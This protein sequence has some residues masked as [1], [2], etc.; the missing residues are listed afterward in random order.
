MRYKDCAE[1]DLDDASSVNEERR[2]YLF[3]T[4]LLAFQGK[5]ATEGRT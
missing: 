2:G 1:P 4:D 3:S 5:Q